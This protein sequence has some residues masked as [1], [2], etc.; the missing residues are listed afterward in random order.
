MCQNLGVP[1]HIRHTP[2]DNR[3]VSRYSLLLRSSGS[4]QN[5]TCHSCKYYNLLQEVRGSK[6]F[7]IRGCKYDKIDGSGCIQICGIKLHTM[8]SSCDLILR[9][10]CLN[11]YFKKSFNRTLLFIKSNTALYM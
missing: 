10:N 3:P 11:M 8:I 4:N 1:W 5:S 2:R 7:K 6:E 9:F